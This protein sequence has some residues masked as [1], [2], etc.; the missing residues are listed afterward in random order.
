MV[1]FEEQLPAH[2]AATTPTALILPGAGYT[3][4]APLLYWIS[5]ALVAHGW[6]LIRADWGF[7]PA[8][9]EQGRRLVHDSLE[10]FPGGDVPDLVV[11]KSIGTFALPWAMTHGAAGIWLTP[12]L[13]ESDVAEALNAAD[14]RHVAIGG[15]A[16][17]AWLPSLLTDSHAILHSVTGANHSLE[18]PSSW[19]GSVR[20]QVPVIQAAVAHAE[21][22]RLS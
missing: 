4:Q 21:R 15:T 5:S 2:P 3:T 7:R 1:T 12:L 6:R 13:S 16:D 17:P 18:L 14:D 20:E 22:V 19:D 11:A 8:S 10:T 9:L